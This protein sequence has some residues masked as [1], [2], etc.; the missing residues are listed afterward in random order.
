M[1]SVDW[2]PVGQR[3]PTSRRTRGATSHGSR[4]KSSSEEEEMQNDG[5]VYG[6]DMTTTTTR[7]CACLRRHRVQ[8]E[9]EAEARQ[10]HGRA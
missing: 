2:K 5:D 9:A 4:I 8:R 7:D 1:Q 10:S 3:L 6:G